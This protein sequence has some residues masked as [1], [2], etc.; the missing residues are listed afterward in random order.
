[1]GKIARVQGADD[2]CSKLMYGNCDWS[3]CRRMQVENFELKPTVGLSSAPV[4]LGAAKGIL[5]LNT[6][7]SPFLHNDLKSANVLLTAD[8][9]CK[10]ADFGYTM[11]MSES[12]GDRCFHVT[13]P[14]WLAPEVLHGKQPTEASD[15]FA[16]NVFMWEFLTWQSPWGTTEHFGMVHAVQQ[17]VRLDIPAPGDLPRDKCCLIYSYCKNNSLKM[18]LPLKFVLASPRRS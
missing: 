10:I 11:T 2:T 16:F 7:E 6:C 8:F 4:M 3:S 5:Y 9:K 18:Q 17:G 1:V 15:V 14:R 13:N 12:K